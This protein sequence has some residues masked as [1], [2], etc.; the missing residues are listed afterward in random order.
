MYVKV[1]FSNRI[2]CHN[3]VEIEIVRFGAVIYSHSLLYFFVVVAG[4]IVCMCV[5]EWITLYCLFATNK[6]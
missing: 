6:A 4:C 5:M 1:I 2:I 3:V